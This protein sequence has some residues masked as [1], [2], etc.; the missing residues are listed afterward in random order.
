[1]AVHDTHRCNFCGSHPLY[2]PQ[3]ELDV[4]IMPIAITHYKTK[5]GK[6]GVIL[7]RINSVWLYYKVFFLSDITTSDGKRIAPEYLKPNLPLHC[8]PF[9]PGCINPSK[10]QSM[11]WMVSNAP[12]MPHTKR[13][14]PTLTPWHLAYA[15]HLNTKM[16]YAHRSLHKHGFHPTIQ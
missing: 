6:P 9:K 12:K 8:K 14:Y 4:A 13:L 15:L 3:R 7:T 5:T 1:M 10:L 11:G 16:A 2:P